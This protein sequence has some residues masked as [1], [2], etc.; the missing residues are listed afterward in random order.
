MQRLR[1]VL[2][3]NAPMVLCNGA[4]VFCV[5]TDSS[6]FTCLAAETAYALLR[7][8]LVVPDAVIYADTVDLCTWVSDPRAFAEPYALHEKLSLQSFTKPEEVVGHGKIAKIGLKLLNPSAASVEAVHQ[9][10]ARVHHRIPGEVH[11]CY[12]SSDYVEFM[13]AGVS[14][15]SGIQMSQTMMGREDTIVAIGDHHNDIEMVS[16]SDLGI[17][18]GN[19]V[20][21]VKQCAQHCTASVDD[22]GLVRFLQSIRITQNVVNL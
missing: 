19:A 8:L 2:P 1:A 18:M 12:S 9:L 14:K 5:D 22:D 20:D 15:W 16:N 21:A 7:E 6:L 3:V 4:H 11:C 13:K 10:V 17:A